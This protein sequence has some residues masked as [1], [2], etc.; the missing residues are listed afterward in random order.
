MFIV[1]IVKLILC[2][3][4]SP[5]CNVKGYYYKIITYIN[6]IIDHVDKGIS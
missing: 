6:T 5:K 2:G 3:R 4:H 1:T